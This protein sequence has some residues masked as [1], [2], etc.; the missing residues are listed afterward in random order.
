MASSRLVQHSQTKISNQS[1]GCSGIFGA[2]SVSLINPALVNGA[3]HIIIAL[4]SS[5][6]SLCIQQAFEAEEPAVEVELEADKGISDPEHSSESQHSEISV[7]QD[8]EHASPLPAPDSATGFSAETNDS[9]DT[10]DLEDNIL[11]EQVTFIKSHCR[12]LFHFMF[13][14]KCFLSNL[15]GLF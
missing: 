2:L 11:K 15:K 5:N 1:D 7:T 13:L 14:L 9:P 6:V 10:V 8:Q 3:K 12:Y 4:N